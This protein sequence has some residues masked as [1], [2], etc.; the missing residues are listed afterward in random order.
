MNSVKL[1][2]MKRE[3]M[4]MI[5]KS[6]LNIGLIFCISCLFGI[7]SIQAQTGQVPELV[8]IEIAVKLLN[9]ET[10]NVNSQIKDFEAAGNPVPQ[11]LQ[12]RFQLFGNVL[13]ELQK[14][15]PGSTTFHAV[16]SN[17]NY[18]G[19]KMDDEAYNDLITGAWDENMA[20]LIRILTK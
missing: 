12:F 5:T 8:S 9:T 18:K 10:E 1:I 19:I 7:N 4:N 20:E 6:I 16:A 3:N 2:K 13:S 11:E 15:N 14:N 17:S